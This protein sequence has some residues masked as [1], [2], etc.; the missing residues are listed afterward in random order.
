MLKKIDIRNYV[1]IDRLNIDF[2]DGFSVMTGETGAG[3]SIILGAMNLLLGGRADSKTLIQGAD[4]CT[5]EGTFSIAGYG[6]EQFFAENELDY[7]PDETIMRREL[8]ASGKSRAFIN[9]T[10]VT[11]TQLRDLGCRLI[12]I[13]SQHQNLAL[14][15]Q[16]FQ[17][18][19][20]DTIAANG[21]A[22]AAYEQ[23]FDKWT[24]LRTR[25]AQ[26]KKDFESDN[27]DREYLEFQLE[28]IDSA[29]LTDG[30]QEELEQESDILDH[31]EEIKQELFGASQILSGDEDSSIQRLRSAM[32]SLRAA[33][34]NYPQAQELAERLDSC[35]IEL[36]DIAETVDDA[37]ESVNFDPARLEQVNE[38]LDLIYSLEKKHKKEN[39][40]QLLEYAESIRKRL[41]RTGSYEFDIEQLTKQVESARLEME[42]QAANLSKTRKK[43][44]DIIIKDIK[45]LLMP[46][47]I[48]N[49]QF[50][51]EMQP[52][53]GFDRTG[54]DDL[55]FMFSANKSVPMQELQTVASG[56]EI[57]RVMLCIKSLM[58]GARAL[59]TVIFDEIDTGVSGAVAEKMA[60]LM[61]RMSADGRQVLAITHLP[62]IAAIGQTHYKVFKTDENDATH[63]RITVLSG[64]DRIR[65]IAGMMSGSTLTQAALDNAKALIENNGR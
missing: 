51:I 14:G 63:T 3:K 16:S 57:A 2:R 37:Q 5:I 42:K 46:L 55:R 24:E 59:P 47:G 65:E 56:G 50:N 21:S 22:K 26:L 34:K 54:H 60:L 15:T 27:T 18:D 29:K 61:K 30:E 11:L 28:G 20:V 41:D 62:Q 48:P 45:E 7:D 17:L 40:A 33:S 4:K 9:D 53:S 8:S 38:R 32:Q 25:L 35:I 58:A 23:S 49:V 19:V 10:P 1:L 36:K 39:I 6:L 43:A 13:H 31:A 52:A 44:S 64:D 12:D